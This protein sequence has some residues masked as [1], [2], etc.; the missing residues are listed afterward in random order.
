MRSVLAS[1][2]LAL[3]VPSAA[4]AASAAEGL[5]AMEKRW[6]DGIWPVVGFAK[7][8]GLP[9]DIVVQPQPAP[10][11]APLSLGFVDGRCKL[12]LSMRE[13]PEVQRTM[14]Q[15]EPALLDA[16]LEL[17]AAHE[18]GHCRRYLDGAWHG[19]P[20]GFVIQEP[21]GL[22]PEQRQAYRAM[23]LTRREEGY[24]DLTGLAWTQR[25]RPQQY[26]RLHAWLL[27]ERS[28]ERLPGSHH[29]TLAWLQLAADPALLAADGKDGATI[30]ETAA[31]LWQRVED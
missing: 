27:A 29:D 12:V 13:N 24:A 21:I 4:R 10:E 11:A 5:T 7:H 30:F 14:E 19:L 22:R 9:L 15:I 20:A 8:Q 25:Q 17:M 3:L 31:S 18:L 26:A 23:R 2:L 6:L 28:R 1:L 16:S